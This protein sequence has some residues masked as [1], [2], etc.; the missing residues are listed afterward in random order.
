[1]TSGYLGWLALWKGEPRRAIALL[2]RCEATL[3]PH[4]WAMLGLV[5]TVH[6]QACLS[7]GDIEGAE[8]A[9]E[10]GRE[11][12]ADD[13]MPPWWPSLAMALDAMVLMER[14]QVDEAR[15]MAQ[16]PADGPEFHLATCFRGCVLLRTG[17]P[18]ETLDVLDTISAD[19]MFPHV[20]GVVETLRAQAR[21]ESGDR[22]GAH[23]A[24]ERALDSSQRFGFFEPF[25]LVG[26]VLTPLLTEH[27]GTGTRHGDLVV[28][29]IAHLSTSPPTSV[30]DW[31]ETLTERERTILH[32]LATDMSPSEI[33]KAEFI[34]V[35]TVKTHLAHLYRKMDVANR[36]A[37]VRHASQLGLI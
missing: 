5:T 22:Q 18:Q 14:G 34:S 2:E 36:R 27:R 6:A 33:A 7:A 11:L 24:L 4:D 15:V 26:D 12:A 23:E 9:A 28:R 32:Y 37:A 30:N 35:N 19:R 31:G 29:V 13:R 1:M 21:A 10:R 8:R 17:R 25:R 20:S 16:H 3:L